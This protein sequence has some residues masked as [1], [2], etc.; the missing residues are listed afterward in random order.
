ML[1]TT[2]RCHELLSHQHQCQS[3][4]YFGSFGHEMIVFVSTGEIAKSNC[5][6]KKVFTQ[7]GSERTRPKHN[8]IMNHILVMVS[9]LH[10]KEVF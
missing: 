3:M 2:I 1:V 7:Y 8:S 10:E 4:K 6:M 9:N 5:E